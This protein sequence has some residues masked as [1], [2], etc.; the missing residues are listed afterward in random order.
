MWK[1]AAGDAPAMLSQAVKSVVK[2]M[3]KPALAEIASCGRRRGWT[4]NEKLK[5]LSTMGPAAASQYSRDADSKKKKVTA[6][7]PTFLTREEQEAK[8]QFEERKHKVINQ[9][10]ISIGECYTSIS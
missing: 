5:E 4:I 1:P 7:K 3:V 2:S 8:K 10:T 6:Q 9:S